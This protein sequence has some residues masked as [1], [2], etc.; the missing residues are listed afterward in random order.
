MLSNEPCKRSDN[1]K[2]HFN[3]SDLHTLVVVAN[4]RGQ[5]SR[6]DCSLARLRRIYVPDAADLL[7]AGH[8][9]VTIPVHPLWQTTL[10]RTSR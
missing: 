10:N 4:K 3:E 5:L 6:A 9:E 7:K 2:N 1:K 8:K